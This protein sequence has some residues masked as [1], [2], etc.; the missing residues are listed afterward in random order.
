VALGVA[1]AADAA[2]DAE[3]GRRVAETWCARCHVIG[4]ESL[5]DGIESTP[6]FFS[7]HDR[8]DGYRERIRT[9]D[10]RRP[11]RAMT[12]D[13]DRD[14]RDDLVAYIRLLQRP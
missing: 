4:A 6:S 10:E 13:V 12:F 2:G 14:G 8:L 11:Y 5:T 9:F 3:E 7:M 1:T